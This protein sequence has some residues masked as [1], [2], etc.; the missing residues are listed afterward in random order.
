[1]LYYAT[2]WHALLLSFAM[3]LYA[4]LQYAKL[5]C[6]MQCLILRSGVPYLQTTAEL[7]ELTH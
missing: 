6:D 2:V 7:A 3:L 5:C 1:M 4:M